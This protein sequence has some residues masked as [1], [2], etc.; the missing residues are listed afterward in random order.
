M[1]ARPYSDLE[2]ARTALPAALVALRRGE[3]G[4][5]HAQHGSQEARLGLG[6]AESMRASDLNIHDAC[7]AMSAIWTMNGSRICDPSGK[8][9]LVFANG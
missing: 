1:K 8:T 2:P 7:S 9:A 5:Q 4:E 6:C 3:D